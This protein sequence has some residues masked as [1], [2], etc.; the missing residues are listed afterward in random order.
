LRLVGYLKGI[1]VIFP[2]GAT[3]PSL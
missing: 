3:I 1:Q 2:T